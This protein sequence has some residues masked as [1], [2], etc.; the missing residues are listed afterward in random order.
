MLPC[1]CLVIDHRW[2]LNV[3]RTSVTHSAIASCTTFLFLPYFDVIW[4]LLLN[5][6]TATWNLLVFEYAT[7]SRWKWNVSNIHSFSFSI[8][9]TD[10]LLIIQELVGNSDINTPVINKFSQPFVARLVRIHPILQTTFGYLRLELYGCTGKPDG[11]L[12]S[13]KR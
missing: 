5:R 8:R 9:V 7:S 11:V 4:D 3:V 2:R 6:C 1:V 13:T 10:L 12:I